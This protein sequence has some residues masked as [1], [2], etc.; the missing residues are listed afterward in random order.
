MSDYQGDIIRG[1]KALET[2]DNI[3]SKPVVPDA[4][5]TDA[6]TLLSRLVDKRPDTIQLQQKNEFSLSTVDSSTFY[7]I[8][9]GD[10]TAV[11]G[12]LGA[13]RD[14]S[15]M[16]LNLLVKARQKADEKEYA[17]TILGRALL[18]K[19]NDDEDKRPGGVMSRYHWFPLFTPDVTAMIE[20]T[21]AK[22]H[23]YDRMLNLYLGINMIEDRYGGRYD[24]NNN[25]YYDRF[26]GRYDERGYEFADGSYLSADGSMLDKA[27]DAIVLADGV[28]AKLTPAMKD[29][30][31]KD[32][33]H[34][35][36]DIAEADHI[37]AKDE[38]KYEAYDDVIDVKEG[39][40]AAK[41]KE[42]L[43]QNALARRTTTQSA[44][45]EI[46]DDDIPP[47]PPS[48]GFSGPAAAAI[49]SSFVET[50]TTSTTEA[51]IESAIPASESAMASAVEAVPAAAIT[52]ASLAA[53]AAVEGVSIFQTGE[54]QKI[55]NTR[56][57]AAAHMLQKQGGPKIKEAHVD[58]INKIKEK[59][60]LDGLKFAN[61]SALDDFKDKFDF[62]VSSYNK[63]KADHEN[64]ADIDIDQE[65]R[66]YGFKLRMLR[67]KFEKEQG[68]SLTDNQF[69]KMLETAGA[70]TK[71]ASNAA[72]EVS[73][74]N[75]IRS[76]LGAAGHYGQRAA[77]LSAEDIEQL[78]KLAKENS[79]VTS[80]IQDKMVED[81]LA[82][83]SRFI[84]GRLAQMAHE[85]DGIEE[86][87]SSFGIAAEKS[88]GATIDASKIMQLKAE[89]AEQ[90]MVKQLIKRGLQMMHRGP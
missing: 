69:L 81:G 80:S 55:A 86:I 12:R 90:P 73:L 76:E 20:D 68:L 36:Q 58:H 61:Q 82:R 3:V 79:F 74:Q 44:T 22:K 26:G 63:V 87:A 27:I 8:M 19:Q 51:A 17:E 18:Q 57:G 72:G 66:S 2:D 31:A 33:M 23:A 24:T 14:M 38:K 43:L 47:V 16:A 40:V 9:D 53:K 67:H 85:I 13:T 30:S 45:P 77:R 88:G 70:G 75:Y 25:H 5:D 89:T 6:T 32:V 29:E 15:D 56:P 11:R 83:R 10:E 34:K 41:I 84:T 42:K 50:G 39:L 64:G 65:T 52:P 4:V 59:L 49:D 71:L 78:L 1:K 28:V 37:D 48:G 60:A 21:S 54:F 62:L 46:K 35:A 7:A